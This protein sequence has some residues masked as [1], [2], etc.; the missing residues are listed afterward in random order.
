MTQ[1]RPAGG[2]PARPPS[3]RI[4]RAAAAQ[5]M[6]ALS[7]ALFLN[8][9]LFFFTADGYPWQFADAEVCRDRR[10]RYQP[11]NCYFEP[12]TNCDP[13][14]G[15]GFGRP[16]AVWLHRLSDVTLGRFSKLKHYSTDAVYSQK[17]CSVVGVPR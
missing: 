5:V 16:T 13:P 3:R 14:R 6:A 11:W 9:T 7:A 10:G 17:V 1:D 8:R 12:I 2:P 15:K 4:L